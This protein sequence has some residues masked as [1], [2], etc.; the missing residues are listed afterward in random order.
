MSM[1]AS[2]A[3]HG[4]EQSVERVQEPQPRNTSALPPL[5]FPEEVFRRLYVSL[6]L[7]RETGP[8][9]GLTSAISGE[10]CTTL[11]LG[12][13]QTLSSDLGMSVLLVD[14]NMDNPAVADRLRLPTSPGLPGV[15]RRKVALPDAVSQVA[16]RLYVIAGHSPDPDAARLLREFADRDLFET[17]RAVGAVT[18]VDLPPVLKHSYSPV[19]AASVDA[20]AL[21]IRAGVTP[22]PLVQEA[23]DRLRECPLRGAVF[24]G[25]PRVE[26]PQENKQ[27]KK[28]GARA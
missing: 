8:V 15:L 11:A 13:A 1:R 4:E 12:L 3:V 20:L 25:D 2:E 24:N 21:V 14:A 16:E 26:P 18:I 28:R 7:P 10:G 17:R 9:V 27:K 23:V 22:I 6:S 19:A 5:P